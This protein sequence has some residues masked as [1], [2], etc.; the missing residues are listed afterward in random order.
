[1]PNDILMVYSSP[2]SPERVDEYNQWYNDFHLRQMLKLDGIVA[3]TRYLLSRIQTEWYPPMA[4]VPDWPYGTHPYLA[5]YEID[6]RIGISTVLATIGSSEELRQSADPSADPVTWG[7]QWCY[8]IYAER[9]LSFQLDSGPRQPVD[10]NAHPPAIWLV[11][12][13]PISADG[14]NE[15]HKW[16]NLQ[17]VLRNDG[18]E[19]ISRYK[20]SR[21][22]G[23][24]DSRAPEPTGEWPHNQHHFL[25]LWEV[26]DV[27]RAWSS[28]R[29]SRDATGAAP[30]A[31][32]VRYP[33]MASWPSLHHADKHIFYEPVTRRVVSP[34]LDLRT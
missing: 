11:P 12:T 15:Y 21:T 18:F 25:A 5:I 17:G 30:R 22:Q 24:I 32:G 4:D 28:R 7:E 20:L 9:E 31:G 33:W 1:M 14:E 23:R 6:R 3:V 29:R 10:R 27:Y 26:S 34:W 8:E 19:A 2:K 16:Y 13:T